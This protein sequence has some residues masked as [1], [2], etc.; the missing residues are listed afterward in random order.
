MGLTRELFSLLGH[1]FSGRDLILLGGGLFLIAKATFEIHDK[2]EVKHEAEL[3]EGRRAGG[4]SGSSSSR[5]ASSTSSSRST[6]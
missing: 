3:G 1:G 4:A 6:R 5:S 2:L